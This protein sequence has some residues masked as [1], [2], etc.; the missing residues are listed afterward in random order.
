MA[1]WPHLGLT[2]VERQEQQPM[3]SKTRP[4]GYLRLVQ[5]QTNAPILSQSD[6]AWEVAA[7]HDARA[8]LDRLTTPFEKE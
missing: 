6:F 3:G 7:Y 5:E 4:A 1:P 8:E 2:A